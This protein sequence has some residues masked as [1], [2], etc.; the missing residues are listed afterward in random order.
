MNGAPKCQ[1]SVEWAPALGANA[2]TASAVAAAKMPA[3]AVN[4]TI[5]VAFLRSWIMRLGRPEP[6]IARGSP[7]ARVNQECA[8]LRPDIQQLRFMGRGA[9]ASRIPPAETHNPGR[10]CEISG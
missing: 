5:R 6:A 4:L 3:F 7:I 10:G 1:S 9:V 8:R 2:P